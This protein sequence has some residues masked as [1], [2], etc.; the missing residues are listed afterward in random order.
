S[1]PEANEGMGVL[2]EPLR[3]SIVGDVR[4]PLRVLL[5]AVALV[6]LVA[7]ANIANVLLARGAARQVHDANELVEAVGLF[8]ERPELRREAGEAAHSLMEDNH[9][10]LERTLRLMDETL[11]KLWK[12]RGQTPFPG[13]VSARG[14][15]KE[16][17]ERG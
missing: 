12:Q 2:L 1:Y 6:L 8:L 9:G 15:A 13:A 5:G 14:L 16:A 3:A 7:C 4:Q 17:G 11:D 10:A